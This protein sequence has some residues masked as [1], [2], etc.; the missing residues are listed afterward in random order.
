[1]TLPAPIE[2]CAALARRF[3]EERALQTAGSLTFTTL[4]SLAP[5][6]AL[7][8]AVASAFPAYEKGIAELQAFILRD[9]LPS[10]RKFNPPVISRGQAGAPGI[11]AGAFPGCA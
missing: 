2:F 11:S 4:L 8:L 3:R 7:V 1:M 10:D 5:L 9:A 6:L